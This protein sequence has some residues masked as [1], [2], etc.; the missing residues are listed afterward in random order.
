MAVAGGAASIEQS[1]GAGRAG[2]VIAID[3]GTTN[4]RAVRLSPD[5]RAG[6]ALDGPGAGAMQ[7]ADYP[8]ALAEI[9]DALGELPIVAAGMVGSTIGWR[10]APY[11]A[12]PAD[13]DAL[14]GGCLHIPDAAMWIVPGVAL[15]AGGR[16]DVMRGEEIQV[17]GAVAAGLAPASARFCQPGTH[18]KWIRVDGGAIADFRTAMTGE[19][20]ALLRAQ[21]TLS[22][23]VRGPVAPGEAFLSGV[24]HG[25]SGRDL[26]ATLFEV[27]AR[28]LLG[29]LAA[30]DASSF[31]SGLLIGAD[32]ASA[33]IT[34][35]E[36]IHLVASGMLADLYRMAIGRAGGA[37]T[38]L[39]ATTCFTAGARALFERL[40]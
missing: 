27:R 2:D 23:M 40:R 28:V 32:I 8:A 30:A 10:E 24:E 11:V 5:G 31:A 7:A 33:A 19:L 22:A 26:I 20:L 1:G 16:F 39:D 14:A 38:V 37:V 34:P 36:S 21:G 15:S 4:R 17:L 13:L 6:P 9:R 29:G 18:N 12:A 3:W 35:G 25:L